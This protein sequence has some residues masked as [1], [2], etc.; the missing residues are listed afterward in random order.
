MDFLFE[1]YGKL[2]KFDASRLTSLKLQEFAAAIHAKG[3]ALDNCFGFIDGTVRP[4]SRPTI[5]QRTAYNGH[6]RTHALKFQSVTTPDGMIVDM[7]GP[8]EGR[9]HDCY[10]LRKSQLLERLEPLTV[11]TNGNRLVLYGNPAYGVSKLLLSPFKGAILTE[12]QARFNRSM[13]SVRETVEWGF[14]RIVSLFA[15]VDFKK[16][17]KIGLQPV[18]K[19][20]L[21]A[22]MLT[23]LNGCFYG[24]ET[25]AFFG[26]PPPTAEEYLAS[27]N[28]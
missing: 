4:I 6:K 1:R 17:L 7:Y 19:L 10:L 26:V 15:F 20:Y 2:L 27:A 3:G 21:V 25:S 22:A 5:N 28:C 12:D 24:T 11:D 14:Q 9:R 8:V 23:N 13:S 16:N 18:G